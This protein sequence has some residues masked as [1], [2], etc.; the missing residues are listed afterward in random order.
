MTSALR[1]IG[2]SAALIVGAALFVYLGG[3]IAYAAVDANGVACESTSEDGTRCFRG[4]IDVGATQVGTSGQVCE[5]V[6]NGQCMIGGV[7][8]GPVQDPNYKTAG[9]TAQDI[10]DK[11]KAMNPESLTDAG[12]YSC[13]AAQ[14]TMPVG[15]LVASGIFVP[16]A[17]AAV[18]QNTGYLLYKQCVLDG[19]VSKYR[20]AAT[21]DLV[22]AAVARLNGDDTGVS[23]Y[24]QDIAADRSMIFDRVLTEY[25]KEYKQDPILE[26]LREPVVTQVLQQIDQG[27]SEASYKCDDPTG[28]ITQF[29]NGTLP[30]NLFLQVTK[31][32]ASNAACTPIGAKVKVEAAISSEATQQWEDY[33]SQIIDGYKPDQVK[34]SVDVGNGETADRYVTV[35]P[36]SVFAAIASQ[37][38]G[39]GFRQL[40]NADSVDEIISTTFSA[41][42]T[43]ILSS[44]EGLAGLS[45]AIGGQVQS[46]LDSMVGASSKRLKDSVVG[47]AIS[48]L[49]S[50]L[51]TER[52]FYKYRSLTL[53]FLKAQQTKVTDTQNK[54]WVDLEQQVRLVSGGVSLNVTTSTKMGDLLLGQAVTPLL[55][56]IQSDVNTS[57]TT[58][59]VLQ[60][61]ITDVNNAASPTM[62]RMALAQVDAL[63]AAQALHTATDAQNAKDAYTNITETIEPLVS[64]TITLWQIPPTTLAT[65]IASTTEGWCATTTSEVV[66]AWLAKWR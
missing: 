51:T 36:G 16:V 26:I 14:Y 45:Q 55:P 21:A 61:L 47:S 46:Y 20:E 30:S 64:D 2:I 8:S 19:M 39:S 41:L 66:Q 27:R 42:Q 56:L 7:A 17:D 34:V 22:R 38:L 6:E 10:L 28:L 4:G 12:I 58:M 62:Q 18:I 15:T 32:I 35:T 43:Q 9:E 57:T 54:C 23:K 24:A 40:E 44:T 3:N 60:T 29:Y 25:N 63:V 59:Q 33:K 11:L 1:I 48:I 31:L 50:A 13:G 37:V 49:N 52:E 65:D 5:T 53:D